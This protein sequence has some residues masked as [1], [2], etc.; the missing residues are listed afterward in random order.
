[1]W[2]N[3]HTH[4]SFC[5]GKGEPANHVQRAQENKMVSLGFSS[6]APLPF[7][8]N[9]CMKNE[10]LHRYLQ[11]IENLRHNTCNITL[12]KGLEIDYIPD[13]ISPLDYKDQLDYTIGSIHFVDSFPDGKRWE[14]D[15]PHASF[16]DGFETIFNNSIE[17]TIARYFELTREMIVKACPDI[18]GHLDKI[19]IQNIDGKLF[20]EEDA[21][22]R[23]EVYQTLEAI[24]QSGAIIEVNTRG[25]YHK[26]ISTTYPSPWILERI[27]QKNIPITISSDAHHPD[28]LINQ[29]EQTAEQ[30]MAIGFTKISI[31]K[32]GKWQP[33]DFTTHGIID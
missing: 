19:K 26:K 15:G 17:D 27:H 1:M 24:R 33:V 29:F 6:H 10:N 25:L 20:S 31:L 18:V 16:L 30:L 5:D 4:S 9:W 14:I 21:W 12:H 7:A 3:Y 8:C 32:E 22:Y 11:L 2:A 23:D 28:D 13:V